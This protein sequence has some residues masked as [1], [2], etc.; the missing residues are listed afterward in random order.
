[1]SRYNNSI[2]SRD[3]ITFEG[4]K[5]E[6]E[7]LDD[8]IS[9]LEKSAVKSK[10]QDAV[11]FD[12]INQILGNRK[13]KYSSVEEAVLD[14]Q[15]RTGLLEFLNKKQASSS[16]THKEPEIFS[17]IPEMKIFIDNY[18]ESRPTAFPEAVVEDLLK[19]KSIQE[20]LDN[21]FDVPNDV[22]VYINNKIIE[23]E[24]NNPQNKEVNLNL[25]K[26]DTS[27]DGDENYDPFELL[28]PSTK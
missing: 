7:W 9:E 3:D 8:F 23:V 28:E 12:E 18:V 4:N 15:K 24:K 11:I 5:Y 1:M 17:R 22:R 26:I 16:L 10:V 25:G 2:F 13:S 19:I 14:M 21:K 27:T 6:P 20:K